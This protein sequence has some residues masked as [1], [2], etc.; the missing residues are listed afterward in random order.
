MSQMCFTKIIGIFMQNQ[1]PD[2]MLQTVVEDRVSCIA[3]ITLRHHT[4]SRVCCSTSVL[5]MV[6]EPALG[7]VSALSNALHLF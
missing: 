5:F 7:Y 6:F 3:S 4:Q 1:T 2:A